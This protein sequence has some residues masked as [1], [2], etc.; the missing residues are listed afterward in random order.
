[1]ICATAGK[2]IS[3]SASPDFNDSGE[4]VEDVDIT[5]SAILCFSKAKSG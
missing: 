2:R 4:K 3:D 5:G 1:M